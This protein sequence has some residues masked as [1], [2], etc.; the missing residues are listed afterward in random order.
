MK[1]PLQNKKG[2][3][4]N[5]NKSLTNKLFL[6]KENLNINCLNNRNLINNYTGKKNSNVIFSKVDNKYN[7]IEPKNLFHNTALKYIGSNSKKKLF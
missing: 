5:G 4:E 1:T 6:N 3:F 7:Y 2:S